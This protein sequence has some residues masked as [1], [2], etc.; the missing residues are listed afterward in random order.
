MDNEILR[1][2]CADSARQMCANLEGK[3][4]DVAFH[5]YQNKDLGHPDIGRLA[6]VMVGTGCTFTE[7]P[8]SAPDGPWGMG[9]RYQRVGPL[10]WN[11]LV[12]IKDHK[13]SDN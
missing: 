3:A 7:P 1:R 2:V 11:E 13:Y 10:T 8:K 12:D 6:F 9:W 5:V 4:A